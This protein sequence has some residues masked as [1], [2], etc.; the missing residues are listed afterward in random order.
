MLVAEFTTTLV[1]GVLPNITVAPVEKY[2]PVM[3]TE[4]PP[5]CMPWLGL[6]PVTVTGE[7]FVNRSL[8][9]DGLTPPGPKTCTVTVPFPAG[10]IAVIFV[11]ELM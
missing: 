8:G 5:T 1:A 6:S 9:F 7:T 3:E 10:A 2:V 4:F 11:D